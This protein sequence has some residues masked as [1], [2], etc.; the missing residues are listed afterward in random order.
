MYIRNIKINYYIIFCIFIYIFIFINSNS[1]SKDLNSSIN[2][3][4]EEKDSNPI[5]NNQGINI[6][7]VNYGLSFPVNNL[8]QDFDFGYSHVLGIYF[9]HEIKKKLY[10]GFNFDSNFSFSEIMSQGL[11]S[12][13]EFG[14][15]IFSF[16]PTLKYLMNNK[17]ISLG[18][19]FGLGLSLINTY[20]E[21]FLNNKIIYSS[22]RDNLGFVMLSGFN[23]GYNVYNKL[24]IIFTGQ[25]NYIYANVLLSD[26]YHYTGSIKYIT[27]YP[28]L[29]YNF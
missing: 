26:F 7:G 4:N 10:I 19:K 2:Y 3:I 25:F 22:S 23:F 21:D 27:L 6:I 12:Y 5:I 1:F 11:T 20:S 14:T 28:G 13:N 18:L 16:T 24:Y 8:F 29:S 17:N 15:R 9:D